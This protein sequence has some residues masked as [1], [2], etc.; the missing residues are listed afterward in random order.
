MI[1]ERVVVHRSE[2]VGKNAHNQPIYEWVE[3]TVDNVIVA[4][5]PRTDIP[6][7]ARPDGTTVAWSLHFPKRYSHSLR[8]ARISVRGEE[9]ARVIGDPKPYTPENTPG[10][11][12]LPVEVE[13][14]DG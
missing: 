12:N 10:D 11:W 13:R 9:P 5:G 14:A 2:M 3:E 4:P 7:V 1:G 6:E 8:G